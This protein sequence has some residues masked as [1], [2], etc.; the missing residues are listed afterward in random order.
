MSNLSP[1]VV[2]L[3]RPA[4]TGTPAF[5]A[6]AA[7][8]RRPASLGGWLLLASCLL[9]QPA[10]AQTAT[11]LPDPDLRLKVAGEILS[12]ARQGDGAVVI[13]GDFTSING[14]AR[15]NL[16][17]LTPAG[18][19]D[20]T[21]NP[22]ADVKVDRVAVAPDGSVYASGRFTRIGGR[23]IGLLAKLSGSGSGAADPNWTHP[24]RRMP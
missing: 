20:P 21:W 5:V 4:A 3:A 11:A 16:A 12:M 1:R 17:R 24:C 7:R 13:G 10:I 18:G 8:K 9:V 15:S 6:G 23:S 2:D 19:L 22:G 14:E